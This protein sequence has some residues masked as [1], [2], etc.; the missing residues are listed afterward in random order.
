MFEG[1]KMKKLTQLAVVVLMLALF[2]GACQ[3]AASAQP[4]EQQVQN[5]PTL[6]SQSQINTFVAQTIEA[7]NQIGTA[8]ALTT[9]AQYTATPTAT[10]FTIPTLTPFVILTPTTRPSGG[11]GAPAKATYAC[12]IIRLR[13][14]A[15]TELNRGQDFDIKMTVVNTG[16]MAW[17]QGFDLKYAGGTVM[18][19]TT[20][21]ELPAMDPGDKYEMVLDATAPDEY[22]EHAMT[23]TVEGRL[24]F[25]YVVI[26]VK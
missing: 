23:W 18:T 15:Y 17:Y 16:T 4:S 6:D 14:T 9:E 22:G 25:G 1:D 7:N 21:I 5:T 3:P 26:T 13:P 20:H 8:V 10:P 11:G 12:D 19:G 24:C 2:I